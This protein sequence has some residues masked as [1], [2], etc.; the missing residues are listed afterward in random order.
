M[1]RKLST[2][3]LSFFAGAYGNAVEWYDFASYGFFATIIAQQFFPGDSHFLSILSA[4]AA[5]A[6]GFMVR[7][8]GGAIMGHIGDKYGRRKT[9]ILSVSLMTLSTFLFGLLPTHGMIGFMAPVLLVLLRL[10]QGLAVGGE[11]TCS[12]SYLAEHSSDKRRGLSGSWSMV[13]CFIGILVGSLIA[14][15]ITN[16]MSS[17]AV[18]SWG[19]RIPFLASIVIGGFG[20]YLRLKLKESPAFEEAKKEQV[21]VHNPIAETFRFHKMALLK[22]IGILWVNA[23]AQYYFFT[24]FI[25]YIATYG[26]LK[27][28][29]A[30]MINSICMVFATLLLPLFG[31]LSDLYGRRKILNLG[32]W[33]LILFTFPIMYAL[34]TYNYY[35]VLIAQLVYVVFIAARS[36]P[37]SAT[38]AEIFPTHIRNTALG[39]GYNLCFAIFGGTAP[40]VA[41]LFAKYGGSLLAPGWYVIVVGFISFIPFYFLKDHRH[42]KLSVVGKLA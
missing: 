16:T 14:T 41:L 28:A 15:L 4:F 18:L 11:F 5:F 3:Y 7:P 39:V 23:V 25:T 32:S 38:L 6:V 42:M 22:V 19:W 17:A 2:D 10:F 36:G 21:L 40:M 29:H 31:W 33:G 12:I 34:I 24:F 37:I 30:D 13:S 1:K 8:I 20:L 35:P 9:L 26:T 27:L